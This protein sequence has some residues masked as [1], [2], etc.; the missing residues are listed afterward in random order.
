MDVFE[1]G[2]LPLRMVTSLYG[3]RTSIL[4]GEFSLG[5]VSIPWV[6]AGLPKKVEQNTTHRGQL[7]TKVFCHQ[8]QKF[9]R[10]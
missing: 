9:Q 10:R 8:L 4:G 5:G 1:V 2:D 7:P 6:W 3:W